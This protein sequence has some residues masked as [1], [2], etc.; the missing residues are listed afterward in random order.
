M[1]N[2][3]RRI[4]LATI[5]T[6]FSVLISC[7]E[8]GKDSKTVSITDIGWVLENIDFSY[9]TGGFNSATCFGW[10][11]IGYSGDI[12]ISDIQ[13]AQLHKVG[14]ASYWSFP[15]DSSHVDTLHRRIH[16]HHNYTTS[17]APNGSVFP[18]GQMEFEI[19]LNNG[20]TA[21]YVFDVP[22]PGQVASGGKNAVFTEDYQGTPGT[23]YAA[24][25]RRPNCTSQNKSGTITISFSSNDSLVFNGY[26]VFYDNTNTAIGQSPYFCTY[27]TGTVA[28]FVNG[29][30]TIYK[31]GTSNSLVLQP[32]DI[33][34]SPGKVYS[35]ITKYSV[36]L[37][38]GAQ[39]LGTAHTYDCLA[40]GAIIAF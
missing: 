33:S 3:L 38:D 15:I 30:A 18:I 22:A 40:I 24:I 2:V 4:A 32:S 14:T 29:G 9:W 16:S 17:I 20:N 21:S 34:Y 23:D 35:D 11:S 12:S 7:S 26:V 6:I 27:G 1:K 28:S 39:Y 36:R 19:G 5:C 31:D 37:S 13:Y 10:F 8:P 25:V